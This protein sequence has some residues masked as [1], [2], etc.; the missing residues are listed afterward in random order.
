MSLLSAKGSI[1]PTTVPAPAMDTQALKCWVMWNTSGP[2]SFRELGWGSSPGTPSPSLHPQV[3]EW[4]HPL[5]P[6]APWK[7]LE[8]PLLAQTSHH[9]VWGLGQE[10]LWCGDRKLPHA[11][12]VGCDEGDSL[13]QPLWETLLPLSHCSTLPFRVSASSAH[14]LSSWR[15]MYREFG[16][17]Q[18]W[19]CVYSV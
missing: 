8:F 4:R 19:G 7:E 11:R 9:E 10:H 3:P 16:V 12:A 2:S 6:A 13:C 17:F 18:E 1:L 14:F 5:I 15:G